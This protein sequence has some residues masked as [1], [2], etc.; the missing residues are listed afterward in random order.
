MTDE[1]K[2]HETERDESG[3]SGGGGS[4]WTAPFPDLQEVMDEVVDG[5]R[6]L[7]VGM[8]SRHPRLEV[9]ESEGV[10]LV[11]L[12]LPGV[13]L[14]DL[15]VSARGDELVV[16]GQRRRPEYPEGAQVR[17]SERMYGRFRRIVRLPADVDADGIR[18]RLEAGLLLVTV[19]RGAGSEGRRIR[20]ESE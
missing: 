20:V 3:S 13:R 19:P 7:A 8:P 15:E 18:A 2:T 12:E 17:R 1:N 9:A 14:E 11:W 6:S 10:F 4:R 16:A 5:F